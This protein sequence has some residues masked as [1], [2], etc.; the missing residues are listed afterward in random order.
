M[1]VQ[2]SWIDQFSLATRLRTPTM[3]PY[4]ALGFPLNRVTRDD[5]DAALTI[6]VE[7]NL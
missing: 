4:A 5:I 1:V 2:D 3:Q 7:G 6:G